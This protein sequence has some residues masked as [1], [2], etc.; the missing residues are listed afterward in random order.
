MRSILWAI[1]AVSTV[2]SG[3]QPSP[4]SLPSRATVRPATDASSGAA[5]K[6]VVPTWHVATVNAWRRLVSKQMGKRDFVASRLK[7]IAKKVNPLTECV[8]DDECRVEIEGA[9]EFFE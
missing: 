6:K 9:A 4:G 5:A 7:R 3:F 1:V 8:T 2:C